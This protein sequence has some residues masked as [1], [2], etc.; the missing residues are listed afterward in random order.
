MIRISINWD[1]I[2]PVMRVMT[3]TVIIENVEFSNPEE[4]L[5]HCKIKKEE[6]SI[7]Y[8]SIDGINMP[9]ALWESLEHQVSIMVNAYFEGMTL[10]KDQ[11]SWVNDS[12][13]MNLDEWKKMKGINDLDSNVTYM[14][15][16]LDGP[17]IINKKLKKR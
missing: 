6:R 17:N 15:H 1:F 13:Y 9:S 8:K 14:S 16:K 5:I 2:S 11:Y 12:G 3:G 4:P 10:G 7:E